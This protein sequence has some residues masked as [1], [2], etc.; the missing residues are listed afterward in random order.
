MIPACR[1]E[2]LFL[3]AL[4]LVVACAGIVDGKLRR[5]ALAGIALGIGVIAF[6]LLVSGCAASGPGTTGGIV[7]A[8]T[9]QD[10]GDVEAA[11]ALPPWQDARPEADTAVVIEDAGSAESASDAAQGPS[12]DAGDSSDMGDAPEDVVTGPNTD[13]DA[14]LCPTL[15][16]PQRLCMPDNPCVGRVPPQPT[17]VTQPWAVVCG[18]PPAPPP[19]Y[20]ITFSASSNA[21]DGWSIGQGTWVI[22]CWPS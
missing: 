10:A 7:A 11:S 1:L 8:V 19:P 16:G 18:G 20:C 17:T 12:V 4:S 3:G 15:T 6:A 14:A 22:C 9:E 13:P 2:M 21:C 5:A